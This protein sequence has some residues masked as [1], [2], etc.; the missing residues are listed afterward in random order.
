MDAKQARVWLLEEAPKLVAFEVDR[1]RF[2]DA[3]RT[4][5]AERDDLQRT[6]LQSFVKARK[7]AL[8]TGV[9][10]DDLSRIG[11]NW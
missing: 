4:V 7:N 9:S 2:M 3:I 1:N 6:I 5:L 8:T 11:D 10:Q